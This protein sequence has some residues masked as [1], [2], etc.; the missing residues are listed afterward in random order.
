[1]TKNGPSLCWAGINT[2]AIIAGE[3]IVRMWNL[4]TGDSYVL[5]PIDNSMHGN[6]TKP[7][8]ICTSLSFCKNNGKFLS[9]QNL[10]YKQNHRE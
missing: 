3:L 9:N 10:N 6:Y 7:Q 5:T 1:M 4:H 8:E 2:L